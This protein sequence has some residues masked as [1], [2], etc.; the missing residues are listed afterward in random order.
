MSLAEKDALDE[1]QIMSA[2]LAHAGHSAS[3]KLGIQIPLS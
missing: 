1:Q 3:H 2:V